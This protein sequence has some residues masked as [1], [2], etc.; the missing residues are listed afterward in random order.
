MR[1]LGGKVLFLADDE[2]ALFMS[3]MYLLLL[4][5]V[6]V[7]ATPAP[8]SSSKLMLSK[9]SIERSSK[10]TIPAKLDVPLYYRSD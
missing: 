7:G 4:T 9:P 8:K 6:N 10:G 5:M 2:L 3:L 1:K